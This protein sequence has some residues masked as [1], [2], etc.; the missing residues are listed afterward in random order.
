MLLTALVY[1]YPDICDRLSV[2]IAVYPKLIADLW[3]VVS[4]WIDVS[5]SDEIIMKQKMFNF[6]LIE[7]IVALLV[8]VAIRPSSMLKTNV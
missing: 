4:I 7:S 1:T 3:V 5:A 8:F 2:Y 6:S